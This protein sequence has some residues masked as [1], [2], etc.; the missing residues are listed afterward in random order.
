MSATTF[1]FVREGPTLS[2]EPDEISKAQAHIKLSLCGI[3]LAKYGLR[4]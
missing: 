2:L 3:A 4:D 1:V